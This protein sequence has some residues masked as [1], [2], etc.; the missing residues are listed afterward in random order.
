M[1]ALVSTFILNAQSEHMAIHIGK[2]YLFL[3]L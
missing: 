3:L 2:F 1:P